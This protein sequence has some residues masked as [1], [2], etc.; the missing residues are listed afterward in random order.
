MWGDILGSGVGAATNIY[1]L[2]TMKDIYGMNKAQGSV[3]STLGGIRPEDLQASDLY[4][5]INQ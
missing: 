2:N 3:S 1:G 4:K 5:L